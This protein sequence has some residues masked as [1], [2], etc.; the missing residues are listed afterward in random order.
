MTSVSLKTQGMRLR[1]K[2]GLK[3]V[4]RGLSFGCW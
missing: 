2:V 1:V 4:G 3:N